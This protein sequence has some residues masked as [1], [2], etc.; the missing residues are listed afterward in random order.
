MTKIIPCTVCNKPAEYSIQATEVAG[1][2]FD[3]TV[4]YYCAEDYAEAV[5]A[6]SL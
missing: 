4:K 3:G 2:P 5:K 1:Q 6:L